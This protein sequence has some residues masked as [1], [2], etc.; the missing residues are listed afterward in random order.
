MQF[1]TGGDQKK[2]CE[3]LKGTKLLRV[4]KS[5]YRQDLNFIVAGT[6][7]GAM[8]IPTLMIS[9]GAVEAALLKGDLDLGKGLGFINNIIIDTHFIKRGRFSRLAHAVTLRPGYI[10]FGIGEDT[11]LIISEGNKIECK[12]S[13]MVIIIDGKEIK[14][15]NISRIDTYTPIMVENLKIDIMADGSKYFLKERKFIIG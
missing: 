13:G 9:G 15:T 12:G 4:I 7:A 5:K 8:A 1:F 3:L 11:A 6:S 10:G 2:L 14:A